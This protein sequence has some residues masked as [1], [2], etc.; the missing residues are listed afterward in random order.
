[1]PPSRSAGAGLGLTDLSTDELKKL[2]G[3]LHRG[4]LP[5]PMR[6][7]TLACVGFQSRSEAILG[8]LRN[9]DASAARA[10]LVSVLAERQAAKSRDTLPLPPTRRHPS[11]V[12]VDKVE[13]TEFTH[14][15]ITRL[16]RRFLAR[17]TSGDRLDCSL[18]E[19]LPGQ[20]SWP[21]HYRL[22]NEEAIYV[23]SGRPL[24]RLGSQF[25][26]LFPGDYISLPKGKDHARQMFNRTDGP[27]RYLI[28]STMNEP[29]VMG[30][31]DSNKIGVI[32]GSAPGGD[33]EARV[34]ESFFPNNAAVDY[35]EDE[36]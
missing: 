10:V 22:A 31:P 27:A 33:P 7:D 20:K 29:D 25:V 23:L 17:A 3:H 6:A 24:L 26:E 28:F 11:I 30:Y 5:C 19:L 8:A 35:W 18:V 4:E 14:E 2:L 13:V 36:S 1:M 12:N 21:Y 34:M 32:A 15:G 16:R 9:L